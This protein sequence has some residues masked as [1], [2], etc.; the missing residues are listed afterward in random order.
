MVGAASTGAIVC[1][2][3][4]KENHASRPVFALNK[5][6]VFLQNKI[7][8]RTFAL[9]L[10]KACCSDGGIGRHA[11]LKILHKFLTNQ[12]IVSDEIPVG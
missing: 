12:Y 11:G 7:L 4:R 3:K 10:R 2:I 5:R 1:G 8:I 9:L 6:S